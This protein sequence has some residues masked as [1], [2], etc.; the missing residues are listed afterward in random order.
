[1][2]F[3]W[4]TVGASIQG[5][6]GHAACQDACR[7]LDTETYSIGVTADGLGSRKYSHIGARVAVDTVI[8]HLKELLHNW[9]TLPSDYVEWEKLFDSVCKKIVQAIHETAKNFSLPVDKDNTQEKNAVVTAHDL[10]CTLTIAVMDNDTLAIYLLGDGVV[11]SEE[12]E[13]YHLLLEPYGL[14]EPDD[15]AS[16]T[17]SKYKEK[18]IILVR[19]SH[20]ITSLSLMTDW[21]TYNS[22]DIKRKK[23]ITAFYS[24]IH[25]RANPDKSDQEKIERLINFLNLD[26]FTE[27]SDDDKTLVTMHRRTKETSG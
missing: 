19:N 10:A 16:I 3:P 15:T 25:A 5:S 26:L 14:Y 27:Y 20:D 4:L 13:D 9:A 22:I 12:L 1:M 24:K 6:R 17:S 11:V 21:L 18:E 23:P 7:F 2:S 8:D